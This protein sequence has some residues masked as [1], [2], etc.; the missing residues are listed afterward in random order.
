MKSG[1]AESSERWASVVSLHWEEMSHHCVI[2]LSIT[3]GIDRR[4]LSEKHV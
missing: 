4:S 3:G 2:V 1:V